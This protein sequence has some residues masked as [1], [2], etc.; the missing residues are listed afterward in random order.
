MGE[1]FDFGEIFEPEDA[2]IF[3]P[4]DAD[5]DESDGDAAED[6]ATEELKEHARE[7]EEGGGVWEEEHG[8]GDDGDPEGEG[9]D[10]EEDDADFAG[11]VDGVTSIAGDH[12]PCSYLIDAP[13]EEGNKDN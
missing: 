5:T 7:I 11:L 2:V 13:R 10:E 1:F 8:G 3:D 9:G 12:F 4:Y 6:G